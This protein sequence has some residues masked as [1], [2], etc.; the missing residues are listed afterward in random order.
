MSDFALIGDGGWGR[1]LAGRLSTNG[2]T[3][4]LVGLAASRRKLPPRISFSTDVRATLADHEAV[5]LAVP[6]GTLG[7]LLQANAS[8]FE[9]HHRVA[10]TARGLASGAVPQRASELLAAL[11]CVR[12]TAVLA[13]AADA[14]AL[15]SGAPA[16]LVVGSAF[17]SWAKELQTALAGPSLRIYTNE[18]PIGVEL[19][20][21]LAAVLAVAL[22]IARALGVGATTEATALTRALAEMDRLVIRLGGKPGTAHGLAGLGVLA[23]LALS[24]DGAAFSAAAALSRGDLATAQGFVELA[25]AARNLAARAATVGVRTPMLDAIVAMFAGKLGAADA[26]TGLMSRASRTE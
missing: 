14:V 4:K 21:A 18:D 22:G 12:Q 5:I 8:A 19:S 10:T 13:G 11:T 25:D 6:V 2:H 1:A 9:G 7:V 3:V 15:E 24:A 16:A 17:P 23:D 20:N 26:M